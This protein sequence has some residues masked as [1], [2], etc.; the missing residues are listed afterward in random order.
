MNA[1]VSAPSIS[2]SAMLTEV[3]LSAWV[4]RKKDKGAS[5]ELTSSKHARAGAAAVNKTLLGDCKELK[6]LLKFKQTVYQENYRRTMPWSD[7]GLR[8]LPTAAYFEYHQRMTALQEQYYAMVET[9]LSAYEWEV[10]RAHESLGELFNPNEYPT[11]GSLRGKFRMAINYIPLPDAGDWRVD[12]SQQGR[13]VLEQHYQQFYQEQLK[14][15]MNDVWDRAYKALSR[16]SERLDYADEGTKKKFHDTLVTNV[17]EIIELL[18]VANITNDPTMEAARAQLKQ[19]LTGVTAA[20]LRQNDTLRR[21]TKQS[22]DD[23]IA[24][25]PG[26]GL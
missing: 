11:V 4:G 16:M 12:I 17:E 1:T 21:Y 7:S 26:L 2:H 9:F 20:D 10:S 3:S 18:G 15:A 24:N 25:L 14:G 22:V 13:E 6:E 8:L 23:V 5:A 19:A